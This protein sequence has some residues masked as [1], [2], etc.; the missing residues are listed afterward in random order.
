MKRGVGRLMRLEEYLGRSEGGSAGLREGPCNPAKMLSP[1]LPSSGLGL[2][3]HV[4][5]ILFQQRCLGH[6]V[7][8]MAIRSPDLEIPVGKRASFLHF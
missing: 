1:A 5:L 4:A 3:L 2:S 7:R 8:L 6:V